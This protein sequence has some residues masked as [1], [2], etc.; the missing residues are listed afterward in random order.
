MHCNRFSYLLRTYALYPLIDKPTRICASSQT[1]IDNIFTN[2]ICEEFQSGILYTD[3]SDHL[4]IFAVHKER[5]KTGSASRNTEYF[6]KFTTDEISSLNKALCKETWS[7]VLKER[8]DVDKAYQL[9]LDKLMSYYNEHI[10]LRVKKNN[11]RLTIRRPW[12]TKG[13]LKSIRTKNALFKQY[14][15]NPGN[16]LFHEKFK[17][18]RNK[19][20][21]IIKLARKEYYF[22]K[23]QST[24]GQSSNTWK[25][26]N[27]LLGKSKGKDFPTELQV[28][29]E[30]TSDPKE[31]V[32]VLNSYFVNIGISLSNSSS[33]G[34]TSFVDT[35]LGRC[36]KS[37]FFKPVIASEVLSIVKSL[38]NSRACGHDG[39]NT[40]I[41]KK[42][43]FNI[44]DPLCHIFNMSLVTGTYPK[45]FKL[46][47]VI[48][49]FKKGD[50]NQCN[51]YRPISILPCI[52]KILERIA[53]NQLYTFLMKHNII[54]PSQYGFR[55]NHSTDLAI[56]DLHDKI[57][58]LFNKQCIVGVLLDLSKAF[59]TLDYKILLYKLEHNGVRG[60]PLA[61]FSDYLS[62]RQQYTEFG[63]HKSDILNL[64]CGV[65]QGSILGPLLFLIYIN[66][67]THV[68]PNLSYILFAD[69]TTLLYAD[70]NLDHIF[71]VFNTELAKLL[72][73]LR[74]NKLSL[75]INKT[76]YI[77]FHSQN[78]PI[79]NI[80]HKLVIDNVEIQ[81]K[82][83]V[84][85]LGIFL[86]EH[87]NWNKQ[88]D[89][90]QSNISRT[91]GI[92]YKLKDIL[93]LKAL[94]LLYNSFILSYLSYGIIIWGNCYTK[95][96]NSLL[97]LQK[98]AVRLCT[99]SQYLAHTDPIFKRLRL[100]KV[101]DLN[102]LQTAIFM[103]K[104]RQNLLPCH[105]NRM[106]TCNWQIHSHNT[107]N[108]ENFHLTNPRT[109]Q[110]SRS[111]RHRGPDIWHSLSKDTK[112]CSFLSTFKRKVKTQ[113]IALYD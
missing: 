40:F 53:Y 49:V 81:Q 76:N 8:E 106:F 79:N 78:K 38:K 28:N 32:N 45:S 59:D 37:I 23:I 60:T 58:A 104:L 52:S 16:I 113:L 99:G 27:E 62:N 109:T 18:Y 26:L 101:S 48:P 31:M 46:A 77:I 51:N 112:Q 72:A 35:L 30:I 36:S 43:I 11:R 74:C 6:R 9:F 100:L 68:S 4:P 25:V 89:H 33:S 67:I 41:L 47:R 92:M 80:S 22:K 21:A 107:R 24:S 61:W 44:V 95:Y 1:L 69:D 85:F 111:I 98:R 82:S 42:I 102:I 54:L 93:P 65:P 57:T 75:N 63:N 20:N 86:D 87:L 56:L 39:L 55:K 66:D 73:W 19:L 96:V 10:P 17:K 94:I 13:I 3:I 29:D 2:A 90:I 110:S 71:S 83:H 5:L 108:S 105:F 14:I 50:R 7:E 84:K 88:Y 91:I 15:R 70:K 64:Q 103:F 34:G 97:K 12:I